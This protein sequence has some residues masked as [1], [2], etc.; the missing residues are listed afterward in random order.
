M[1]PYAKQKKEDL[2][3]ETEISLTSPCANCPLKDRCSEPCS[4]YE[5]WWQAI[6]YYEIN[7]PYEEEE[8][9]E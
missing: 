1:G 9:L 3:M 7:L 6:H 8:K 4:A 5:N 2:K